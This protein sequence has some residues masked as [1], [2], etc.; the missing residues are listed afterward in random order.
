VE[1]KKK[2]RNIFQGGFDKV[3]ERWNIFKGCRERKGKDPMSLMGKRNRGDR[4]AKKR[5]GQPKKKKKQ[6]ASRIKNGPDS[7][8]EHKGGKKKHQPI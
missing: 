7:G 1:K 6:T 2:G 3:G 5:V 4:R 8:R